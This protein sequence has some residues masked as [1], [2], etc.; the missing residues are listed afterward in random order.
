MADLLSAPPVLTEN[1]AFF[2][3]LD[4][5]LAEIQPHPD[6]VVVPDAV[7]QSLR[8]LAIRQNGAMALISGRSL[9][10]LDALMT[11]LRL[12]LAGAHGAERRDINGHMHR[13]SLPSALPDAVLSFLTPALCALPGCELENKGVAFALHYR[14]APEH[15]AAI[16]T[17]AAEA[18]KRFPALTLQPGKCVIE[19]KPGGVNKGGAIRDFMR[20][21]PFAGR[22]PVFVGDDQTDESGFAVVNQSGGISVKVG[23][24]VTCAQ[25]R[26]SNVS[27]VH[28]W[29]TRLARGERAA[30]VCEDRGEGH[31]SFSG[32]I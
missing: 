5:T 10:A 19:L 2:F 13:V 24:G 18:V 17:L 3:D 31:G 9:R 26:L 7:R 29:V 1:Y 14:Q 28:Q 6:Q 4:G 30:G 27:G 8:A 16:L 20:E 15:A 12:P 23:P 25:W 32:S 22:L 21:A 11:P